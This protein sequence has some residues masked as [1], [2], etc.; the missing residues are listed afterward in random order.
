MPRSKS[1]GNGQGTVYK[2]N[3]KYRAQVTRYEA[4]RRLTA[5]RSGFKTK[6]EALEWCALNRDKAKETVFRAFGE[7]S[8]E[9]A[10]T[11]LPTISPK[12]AADYRRVLENSEELAARKME[13]LR[14]ADLQAV[15]DRQPLAYY[16]R[17]LYKTVYSMVF[18]YG[19]SNGYCTTNYAEYI[20]LPPMTQPDKRAYTSEEVARLWEYYDREKDVFSG[21]ALIMIYTGMR[22]GEI[23]TIDPEDIHLEEGYMTGGI[24]TEAGR[25]GEILIIEK[26]R[27]IIQD[28]ML[29]RNRVA[30]YSTE[31]FRKGYNK[32]QAAAGIERHT[33][34]ECRHTTA[35]LLA[36]EGVHP[37]VISAIMR[38]TNYAQ[39]MQYT[40][41]SR[42]EK[43][44]NLGKIG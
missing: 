4:G 34:H 19:V 16:S 12:K 41:V 10:K 22:Y 40:H 24:K 1:R 5:S 21:A 8:Q 28:I 26:I 44:A 32:A 33:V 30:A 43:L 9:W 31:G 35:T 29:P 13:D 25:Q 20:E 7:V 38:H 37:A 36:A 3:G 39:T 14:A 17:K 42:A 2:V 15:V 23:S 6:R 11:H 27:P 18:R